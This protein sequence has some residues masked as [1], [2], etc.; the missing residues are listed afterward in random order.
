M[1]GRCTHTAFTT[2]RRQVLAALRLQSASR[3]EATRGLFHAVPFPGPRRLAAGRRPRPDLDPGSGP[4]EHRL[5]TRRGRTLARPAPRRPSPLTRLG[6]LASGMLA[7]RPTAV[8]ALALAAAAGLIDLAMAARSARSTANGRR[9][10]SSSTP[11]SMPRSRWSPT[12]STPRT[13]TG[14]RC[15]TSPACGTGWQS[16]RPVAGFAGRRLTPS[17]RRHG[18]EDP[19]RLPHAD[20]GG[21]GRGPRP[22]LVNRGAGDIDG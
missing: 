17:P 12:T 8:E 5:A 9:S 1:T 2:I 18:P 4:G 7:G 14:R 16:R 6:E 11:A 10:G 13:R 21:R 19:L 22:C 3:T 15:S 20:Q